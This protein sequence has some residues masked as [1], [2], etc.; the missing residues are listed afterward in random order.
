MIDARIGLDAMG[1][2]NA[3]RETVRGAV[4]A[5]GRDPEIEVHLVGEERSVWAEI[6]AAG[7]A[8]DRIRVIHASQVVGCSDAPTDAIRK[9]DSSIRRGAELVQSRAVD[10]L[11][12]AGNTG[13]AVAAATVVIGRLPGVQR[14]GI[15]VTL[16]TAKGHSVMCD[17]GANIHCKP[18][19]LYHYGIMAAQYA[20]KILGKE[21][22]TVGLLNVGSEEGKGTGL[23]QKTAALFASASSD[24]NY[25]GNIEGN[26]V[27]TGQCDVIVCEGFVGNV[28]LK[29]AEGLYEVVAA[30][31]KE[32][33]Q[34][35]AA[36]SGEERATS[37]SDLLKRFKA[38]MDWAEYGGAPL[39]GL[40]GLVLISHGRS[41]ARAIRNAIL[42]AARSHRTQVLKAMTSDLAAS[43]TRSL[44]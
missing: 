43:G 35:V 9:L 33:A 1:G 7:G 22:P 27:F 40:N 36:A 20:R 44:A 24:L 29:T 19:H 32:L 30:R 11:V 8:R 26:D 4:D 38:N 12:A 10:G 39:L 31:L 41:D 2:D 42:Q 25:A 17:A 16:P 18:L 34:G 6:E 3:P 5:V 14:P 15:A 13:A 23:V 21:H 28:V 37:I